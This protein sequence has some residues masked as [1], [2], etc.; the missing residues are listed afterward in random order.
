MSTIR[1]LITIAVNRNWETI[2]LDASNAFL[3]GDISEDLYMRQPQ[4]FIDINNPKL[5]CKLNKSLYGLKQAPRNWFEK[6]T[7]FLQKYGFRSSHSNS[8]LFLYNYNNI[9]IFLLLYV[10]DILMTGNNPAAIRTLISAMHSQFALKN[11]GPTS[12]FL[13][14]QVIRQS[15]GLFLTQ[16]HYAEKL[17]KDSGLLDSKPTYTPTAPKSKVQTMQTQPFD[18]PPLYR[19]LAGSLQYLSIT[20]PDIAFAINQVCQH[21]H[22]PTIQDFQSLKRLLRYIKGTVTFNIPIT[23]GPMILRT[24]TDADWAS[25]ASDRKSI[26]GFCTLGPNLISW[27]VKKQVTVAKSSTEADYRSLSAATSDVI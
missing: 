17:L 21:M 22:Q 1:T 5:L 14:I 2:Q 24:Y 20:R 18:D 19:R 10:D 12:L 23:K 25:D 26:S 6:F 15:T 16:Q 27:S 13:G 9:Q 11:L 7:G 8:S 4:G 3:H